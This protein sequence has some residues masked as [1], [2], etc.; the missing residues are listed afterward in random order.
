MTI[1]LACISK[2]SCYDCSEVE[3]LVYVWN[4]SYEHGGTKMPM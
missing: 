3:V 1:V 4:C 2:N